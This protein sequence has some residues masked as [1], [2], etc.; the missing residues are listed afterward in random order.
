MLEFHLWHIAAFLV[1][2]YLLIR[3]T[4]KPLIK[5]TDD[6]MEKLDESVKI[7]AKSYKVHIDI[8]KYYH[9]FTT[10]RHRLTEYVET[11]PD[12]PQHVKILKDTLLTTRSEIEA[13][14][15]EITEMLFMDLKPIREIIKTTRNYLLD[16]P[17]AIR[18]HTLAILRHLELSLEELSI[19]RFPNIPTEDLQLMVNAVITRA[20][21]IKAKAMEELMIFASIVKEKINIPQIILDVKNDLQNLSNRSQDLPLLKEVVINTEKYIS[22]FEKVDKVELE[23]LLNNLT[24]TMTSISSKTELSEVDQLLDKDLIEAVQSIDIRDLISKAEKT[25]LDIETETKKEIEKLE[26]EF[27]KAISNTLSDLHS[28][29]IEKTVDAIIKRT[30]RNVKKK[31]ATS[32]ELAKKMLQKLT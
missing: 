32:R 7:I 8:F 13:Y 9:S 6:Y 24:K 25:M 3:F 27:N 11:L 16:M 26:Q 5:Y 2:L 4:R 28:K 12:T 20:N 31:V 22:S 23:E 19:S 18:K 29:L 15:D 1:F 17:E 10:V 30:I 14:Q 21:R